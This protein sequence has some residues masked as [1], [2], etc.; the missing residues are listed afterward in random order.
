MRGQQFLS[1]ILDNERNR[2]FAIIA[3]ILLVF[4]PL[5]GTFKGFE[6]TFFCQPPAVMCS[7]FLGCPCVSACDGY[8]IEDAVLPVRVTLKC[9]AVNFFIL[10]SAISA[11][12]VVRFLS[13]VPRLFLV[14]PFAY[15]VTILANFT[16]II[17]GRF[18]GLAARMMLP[19]NLWPAVHLGT[20]VA[21]FI[22]FLF[23]AYLF[24]LWSLN[25]GRTGKNTTDR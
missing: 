21:V 19:E 14:L 15:A 17:S 12:T 2:T 24:L 23:A 13:D 9:S 4:L 20:G 10:L 16:R 11:A 18:T 3:V 6:K 5:T 7:F 22:I 8:V 25:Y 1:G